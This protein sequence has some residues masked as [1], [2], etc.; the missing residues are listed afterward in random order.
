MVAMASSPRAR[1]VRWLAPVAIALA[2]VLAGVVPTLSSAATPDLPALSPQELI[3]KIRQSSTDA[4]SGTL[5]LSADLGIPDL[6][7]IQ[8][9]EDASGFNPLTLL[10]GSHQAT[11]RVDGRDRQQVS[12]P[13]SLS[14]LDVYH[15]GQDVWTW[16]SD[17][18]KVTHL[19]LPPPEADQ[20]RS[21]PM[22]TPDQLATQILDRITPSTAVSTATPQ[23]V[24]GQPVY[25]LILAPH[26]A[27]ST[28]DH[29][30]IAAD[31]A[32]GM[33]LRVSVFAKGQT[34]PAIQLGFTSIDFAR[35]T[36]SFR[37]TPPPG[38]TVT[39]HDLTRDDRGGTEHA[40]PEQAAPDQAKTGQDVVGQDWTQVVIANDVRLPPAA[41][42]L[43]EAAAPV[44]GPFGSGRV[45]RTNLVSLL[46]LD[47]GRLAAGFV[48]P[49]ALEAAVPHG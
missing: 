7:S 44:T 37:F 13:G 1:S 25:E 48:T 28:I 32:N 35:P 11:I 6:G 46:L 39:T 10:S 9:S 29:V 47:D 31:A 36:G 14:E 2:I 16:Q 41:K 42:P 18:H 26:S 43:Y 5:E 12:M 21:Q 33:A 8:G 30:G 40:A 27:D 19:I 3:A 20:P 34:A 23:Y 17:G 24:A 45:L 15:D 22:P 49:G 4:F 38:A